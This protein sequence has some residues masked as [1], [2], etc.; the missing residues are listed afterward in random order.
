M[1]SASSSSKPRFDSLTGSLT[2][3]GQLSWILR[4]EGSF[5]VGR[6]RDTYICFNI[7]LGKQVSQTLFGFAEHFIRL[8]FPT[9]R[10]G[11]SCLDLLSMLFGI[12]E[13]S[14]AGFLAWVIHFTGVINFPGCKECALLPYPSLVVMHDGALPRSSGTPKLHLPSSK[15]TYSQNCCGPAVSICNAMGLPM[16]IRA[17]STF[18]CV[19]ATKFSGSRSQGGH[20]FRQ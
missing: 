19:I 10:H 6:L 18:E 9:T 7:P 17:G 14:V 16:K 11:P 4:W 5:E 2:W 13:Q 1:K 15:K 12:L 20:F 3:I 8:D